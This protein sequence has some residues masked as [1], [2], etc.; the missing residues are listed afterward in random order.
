MAQEERQ[1]P[2]QLLLVRRAI[3]T[4]YES[5][6]PEGGELY[7]PLWWLHVVLLGGC[8]ALRGQP[9]CEPQATEVARQAARDCLLGFPDDPAAAASWRLQR[10]AIPYVY[11]LAGFAPLDEVAAQAQVRL[12]AEQR[13][14]HNIH[15]FWFLGHIV[16]S[17]TIDLLARVDPWTPEELDRRASQV[18]T[19]L[20]KL[21]EPPGRWH[22]GA[23]D[24]W[25]RSWATHDE[26]VMCGLAVLAA[27]DSGDDLLRA[28][29]VLQQV[30]LREAMSDNELMRRAA[31]PLA[32]R[33]GLIKPA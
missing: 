3:E 28:D 22:E 13:L 7:R 17:T 8:L 27:E 23:L 2:T 15:P 19:A 1:R 30:I 20:S 6:V 4:V 29:D 9:G 26:L 10:V 21:P 12:S 14:R 5:R 16:R 24:P 32:E 11:R 25:L 31:V 33:L 18:A